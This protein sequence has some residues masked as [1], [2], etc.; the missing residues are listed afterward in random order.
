MALKRRGAEELIPSKQPSEPKNWKK[1]LRKSGIQH[2]KAINTIFKFFIKN[3]LYFTIFH[4]YFNRQNEPRM[5]ERHSENF[6]D[7]WK[8]NLF[9]QKMISV[10]ALL[11]NQAQAIITKSKLGQKK[12]YKK[13]VE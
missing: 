8:E 5:K 9:E 6:R 2:I 1:C 11:L 12:L 3:S 13:T 10:I 4:F 7:W